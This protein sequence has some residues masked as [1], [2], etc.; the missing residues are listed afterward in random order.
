VNANPTASP[1]QIVNEEADVIEGMALFVKTISSNTEHG[2]SVT[3]HRKVTEEPEGTA[4]TVEVGDEGLVTV[5]EPEITDQ[6]P[7]PGEGLLPAR[8]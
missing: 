4:E 2:P 3:V 7:V 8:V 6:S 5:A 1:L